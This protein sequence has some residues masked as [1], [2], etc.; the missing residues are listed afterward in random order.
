MT[1]GLTSGRRTMLLVTALLALPFI[2]AFVLYGFEWRPAK[3]ANHGQLIEP[4]RA[5]PE[6]GLTLVDGRPLPTAELRRK[7]TLVLLASNPCAS[8][9]QQDL[10]QIRQVQVAL[11][12]EMVRLRRVLL[13]SSV[14]DL[15]TDP[16]LAE[17]QRSYPDLIIAAPS[18]D[19]SGVIWRT[20]LDG[21]G[22]RFYVIDPLG[23]VMMRYPDKPEM[24][25]MLRD[26]ERLLKYSWVG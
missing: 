26:L 3:L 15:R 1:A 16:A 9:C 2:V 21:A 18:T 8:A 24:R 20:T 7:W 13:G 4:A 17:I 12:K 5:L 11:N 6:T 19:E 10:H 23:N 25:G 22:Y 14:A